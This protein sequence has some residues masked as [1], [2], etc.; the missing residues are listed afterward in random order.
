MRNSVKTKIIVSFGWLIVWIVFNKIVQGL[1]LTSYRSI[2]SLLF[3]G[4]L[5]ILIAQTMCTS[6]GIRWFVLGI[7]TILLLA[8]FNIVSLISY[9]INLA[10]C[11]IT[12]QMGPIRRGKP[13]AKIRKKIKL[14]RGHILR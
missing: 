12:W 10:L 8:Q 6:K 13:V 14:A 4:L 7:L 11:G 2:L 1:N 3:E 5:C 9:L